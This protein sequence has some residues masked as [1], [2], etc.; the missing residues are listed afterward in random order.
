MNKNEFIELYE[1]IGDRNIDNLYCY[2]CLKLSGFDKNK[3]Y[4]LINLLQELY[5]NDEIGN[6]ISCISDAL[7][8]HYKYIDLDNMTTREILNELGGI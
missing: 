7:Y 6:S 3:A 2:S 8:D 1:K 4:E 5:I